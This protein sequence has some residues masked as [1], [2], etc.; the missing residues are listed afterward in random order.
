MEVQI[1]VERRM[2][3]LRSRRIKAKLKKALRGLGLHDRELSVLLTDDARMADLNHRYLGKR[4]PTN[5]LAF[6]TEEGGK[7]Q[8]SSRIMGDVVVSVETALAESRE[9]GEPLEKTV[10]RLLVH[11]VL[12]LLDYDHERS[13]LDAKRMRREE[14]RVLALIEEE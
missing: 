13:S 14:E 11:G 9:A 12:H 5:V 8:L 7:A 1:R 10:D 4:G 3:G 6:P 2:R